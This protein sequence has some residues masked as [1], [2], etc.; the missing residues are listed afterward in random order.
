MLD[1]SRFA[2]GVSVFKRIGKLKDIAG[3]ILFAVSD[4]ATFITGQVINVNG[5]SIT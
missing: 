5:G 3:P 4:L 1:L 2:A